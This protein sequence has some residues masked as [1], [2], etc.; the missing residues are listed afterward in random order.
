ML[1]SKV[2]NTIMF[3]RF[4]AGSKDAHASSPI[5]EN[6]RAM[7][8]GVMTRQ[9]AK[10]SSRYWGKDLPS[11]DLIVKQ[12]DRECRKLLD[13]ARRGELTPEQEERFQQCMAVAVQ[14]LVPPIRGKPYYTLETVDTGNN[15]VCLKC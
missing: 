9:G 13:I 15:S 4:G 12:T 10:Q 11:L 7:A 2:T 6:L 8:A 3:L 5:V 1:S 14:V